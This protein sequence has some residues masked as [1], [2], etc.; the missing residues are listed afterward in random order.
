MGVLCH[1][2]DADKESL[3]QVRDMD[4]LRELMGDIPICRHG[5]GCLAS[6]INSIDE[7]RKYLSTLKI[8]PSLHI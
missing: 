1:L 3:P 4:T 7:G 5:R 8:R 6:I 2:F